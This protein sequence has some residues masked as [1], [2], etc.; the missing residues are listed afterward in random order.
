M[1]Q[2]K[3]VIVCS[4]SNQLTTCLYRE[5]LPYNPGI[6]IYCAYRA[7]ILAFKAFYTFSIATDRLAILSSYHDVNTHRTILGAF[8]AFYASVLVHTD[9]KESEF[10]RD[11]H[12]RTDGTNDPTKTSCTDYCHSQENTESGK[13]QHPC[14]INDIIMLTDHR[15]HGHLERTGGTNTAEKKQ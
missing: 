3:V 9:P 8:I 11:G 13:P 7:D 10:I 14:K 2:G 4:C 12:H 5:R 1:I 15:R 6:I